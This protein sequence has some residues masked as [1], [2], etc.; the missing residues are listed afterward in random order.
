ML[1]TNRL[2]G[3]HDILF[4]TLDTLRYDV[5]E[6]SL[7]AAARRTWRAVLP[8]GAGRSGTRPAAS[9][10]AAHARSSPGFLPTPARPGQ[11]PRLFALRFPGQRDDH[12][13]GPASS[14]RPTSSPGLRA[15]ATTPICIGGVGFFNKL[16]PLGQRAAGPVRREPLV[17]RSWA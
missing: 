14:T 17:R 3:T 4:V 1:D 8:G 12:G 13:R 10:I 16:T 9:P 5:A 6:T 2:V 7:R 11:H 15:A